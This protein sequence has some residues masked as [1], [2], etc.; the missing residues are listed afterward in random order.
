MKAETAS[1]FKEHLM[2]VSSVV[3]VRALVLG[4]F[5]RMK[6][7]LQTTP[8]CKYMNPSDVP[9]NATDLTSKINEHQG[10]FAYYR[11][12]NA[13]IYKLVATHFASYLIHDELTAKFGAWK[14]SLLTS[15][16]VTFV[17]Y[18]LDSVH[19]RMAADCSKKPSILSNLN[20]T[21]EKGMSMQ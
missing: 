4:P 18:P 14:S 2:S 7:V 12:M 8:V 20:K 17:S 13:L 5:E 10:F 9:K 19:C 6:I 16:C 1:Q 11:G 3:I 15:L 21:S